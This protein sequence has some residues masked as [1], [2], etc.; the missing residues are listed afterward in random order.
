M[1]SFAVRAV[2]ILG[3]LAAFVLAPSSTPA[4]IAS[5][6]T[7]PATAVDPAM[8]SGQ[9]V[10][11]ALAA[12]PGFAAES[13]AL[14]ALAPGA[15]VA[16]GD[17][18]GCGTAC[19]GVPSSSRELAQWLLTARDQGRFQVDSTIDEIWANEIV[20]IANG[21]V[22]PRCDI[23]PRVLQTLVVSVK[24]FG[25]AKINDLNRWCAN[26]GEYNCT[27]EFHP[28]SPWHCRIPAVAVDFGRVGTQRTNGWGDG[29]NQLLALMNQFM[30]ANTHLGQQGCYGRPSMRSLGY[31]NLTNEFADACNHL[32]VDIGQSSGGLR[33]TSAAGL[34]IGVQDSVQATAGGVKVA[35]WAVDLDTASSIAVDVTV[36]GVVKA[37]TTASGDRPDIAA[38]FPGIGN[39][40]GYSTFAPAAPGV[41][42][43]CTLAV[44]S[45]GG[46]RTEIGCS[47]VTVLTGSP[48]G[49]FDSAVRSG[50]GGDIK[51]TGWAFDPDSTS[52][53]DVVFTVNGASAGSAKAQNQRDDV[54]AL[55]PGY[56]GRAGFDTTIRGVQGANRVCAYGTDMPSGSRGPEIGCFS[57]P[58]SSDA[59]GSLDSATASP[60]TARFVGWAVDAD[61]PTTALVIRVYQ[62]GTSTTGS[63][64]GTFV[65]DASRTDVAGA[66]P[67]FGDRHGFDFSVAAGPGTTQFCLY[68]VNVGGGKDASLGCRDLTVP[69][70]SPIG[71]LD[72][73]NLNG[74]V[75]VKGWSIDPDSTAPTE[76]HVYVNGAG[77]GAYK[78]DASRPDVGNAYPGYG[79]KHGFDISGIR[80]PI[81]TSDICVF[82][83][84]V[85]GGD[86]NTL[87]ACRSVSNASGSPVGVVDLVS[88]G[89]GTITVTG[90][91]LDPDTP[92]PIDIHVY[93][94]GTWR[95]SYSAAGNRPDIAAAFPGYG[96]K[97]GFS[98][99]VSADPGDHQVC[100]F[101]IQVREGGNPLL[102]CDQVRVPGGDPF[103]SVDSITVSNGSITVAGWAIDPDVASAI[104]VHVYVNGVGTAITANQ[105][106]PDVAAV[107]PLY[108][109]KHGYSTTVKAAKGSNLVC[110]FAIN[111]GSGSVNPVLQC[112]TVTV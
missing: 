92:N 45:G 87:F 9:A 36:N 78:A 57:L 46:G 8:A 67:G 34:P 25:T 33:V 54:A 55:Y 24:A 66:Y 5:T 75:S 59:V 37:S 77:Y 103:G 93:I 74:T 105:S 86:A 14:G 27:G 23:D 44:D 49:G 53:I 88:P 20:P 7:A 84:D 19:T 73:V 52:P 102:R 39:K 4:V 98:I 109:P 1:L 61:Q 30:P 11:P 79:A 28:P 47:T 18:A 42:R 64:A 43:V 90:W 29:S 96:A 17:V 112:A 111:Q 22:D 35:G 97:H 76:V 107:Y 60:L 83:I 89:F 99:P 40:H 10:E 2:V 69:T 106:R 6:V 56:G 31:D 12:E 51:V 48:L 100:V 21:T 95:G 80:V 72:V 58:A 110:I 104:P 63:L 15:V 62:G 50:S 70:A 3:V 26:D 91:A 94:D 81:G 71:S 82:G 13:P 38:L 85:V 41:N 68:A 16:A 108:G 32:H 101:A 65:A